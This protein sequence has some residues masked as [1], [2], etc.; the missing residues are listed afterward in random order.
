MFKTSPA[1]SACHTVPEQLQNLQ[2]VNNP[3]TA[4]KLVDLGWWWDLTQ[5][6]LGTQAATMIITPGPHTR[7]HNIAIAPVLMDMNK[8]W[9]EVK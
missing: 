4:Q 2:G 6:S 5:T 9:C 7:K 3:Q 8:S 1:S